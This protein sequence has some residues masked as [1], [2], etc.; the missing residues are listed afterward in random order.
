MPEK[1]IIDNKI[2]DIFALV[3]SFILNFFRSFISLFSL[4]NKKI[5]KNY[6]FDILKFIF[7]KWPK[8]F[9]QK[10]TLYKIFSFPAD[11]IHYIFKK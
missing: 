10:P 6:F 7:H 9:W 3:L 1:K 2:F 11:L 5:K 8:Y 4:K